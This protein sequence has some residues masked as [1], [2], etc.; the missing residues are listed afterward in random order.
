MR[1]GTF[2]SILG[3]AVLLSVAIPACAKD[4]APHPKKA[5][6]A[7]VQSW[8][9][10]S[11]GEVTLKG[12]Q[13]FH[14]VYDR[15]YVQGGGPNAGDPRHDRVIVHA[16]EVAWDG[17]RAAAITVLDSGIAEHADTAMRSLMMVTALDDLSALFEIGPVPGKAKDYYLARFMGKD[18]RFTM[19]ATDTQKV[20]PEKRAVDQPGFG[21]G[22]WVMASMKLKEGMQIRLSP[23]F[24][25]Q[26]N[27]ISQTNYGKVIGRKKITDGSGQTHDAWVIETS[28]WYGLPSPKV[29]RIHVK[30][31]PPYLLGT[32]RYN[33]D[34][35]ESS[36][37]VWLRHATL[38]EP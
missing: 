20:T 13:P 28:G 6:Y 22:T 11:P 19:V 29:L 21:P 32:D 9:P 7:E 31:T 17:R 35:G 14:A 33:Y 25:P 24:S 27:P 23:Y 2:Q 5:V 30:D 34:T 36:H 3:L 4:K 10:T 38:L 1:N 18:V 15:S 8:A 26:A 16:D 37:F 12:F